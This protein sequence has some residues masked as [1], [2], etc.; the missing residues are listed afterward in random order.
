MFIVASCTTDTTTIHGFEADTSSIDAKAS[1][2]KYNVAIRSDKEWT[3]VVDAP[4]V[5]V[6]PAN[7]RGEVRC[8]VR[9]DSTLI[10]DART[11]EIRFSSGGALLQSVSVTQEGYARAIT[12]NES[13]IEIAASATRDARHFDIEVSSNVEFVVEAEYDGDD[14]WLTIDDYTLNLD[15]GARPRSTTLGISWKMNHAPEQRTATLHLRSKS[16]DPIE[17]PATIVVHQTAAPL[18]EDNRQGDSL[19][20]IA[21]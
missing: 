14:S 13:E 16:G 5:M 6:S 20:I 12:P 17:T 21:I 8:E 3:A 4:W 1:G 15:R 10:N 9:I 2:G 18:I 19:A 7:G 11:T